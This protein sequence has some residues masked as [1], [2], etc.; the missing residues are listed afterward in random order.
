M[1]QILI[2]DDEPLICGVVREALL[3]WPETEVQ[4]AATGDQGAEKIRQRSFDLAIIDALLPHTPGIR[5][6][7]I[8]AAQNTPVMLISGHPEVMVLLQRFDFPHLPKPFSIVDLLSESRKIMLAPDENI[9]RVRACAARM[10]A[11]GQASLT[12]ARPRPVAARA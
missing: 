9:R 1:R 4:C 11:S 5:L 8:A 6:A 10:K 7:E 3:D 2:V 12:G